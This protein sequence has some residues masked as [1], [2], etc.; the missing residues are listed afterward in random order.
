MSGGLVALAESLADV[1]LPALLMDIHGCSQSAG[2]LEDP[3]IGVR[4]Q[5]N[6]RAAVRH[7]RG[8]GAARVIVVGVRLGFPLA[9]EALAE[10]PLAAL[11]AWAPIVSGKRYVRELK[12]MQRA[13]DAEKRAQEADAHSL[14]HAED[15]DLWRGR[16]LAAE[17]ELKVAQDALARAMG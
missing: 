6:I 12:V 7:A 13:I 2:R 10:E 16:A 8:T 9:V 14:K 15:C 4:W 17:F 5:S 1:G 3:D 11:V